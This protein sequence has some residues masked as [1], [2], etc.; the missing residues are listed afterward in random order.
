MSSFGRRSL[1]LQAPAKINLGLKILGRRADGYHELESIF[2][3]L[4]LVDE[5][6]LTVE[7]S[8]QSSVQLELLCAQLTHFGVEEA[9]PSDARNLAFRAAQRFLDVADLPVS[10]RLRL[11]KKIPAAAGLGGGSSDAAAVLRG[12]AQIF[13]Q[14]LSHEKLAELALELGADLPFFLDP[15]PALITGIGEKISPLDSIPELALLLANPG[16]PLATADVYRA[17]D[18][19]SLTMSEAGSTMR[20]LWGICESAWFSARNTLQ[21]QTQN[22]EAALLF[23]ALLRNDLEP[24]ATVLCPAIGDLRKKLAAAGAK[25]VGLSGSGPTV[26]GI[27]EDMRAARV[28]QQTLREAAGNAAPVSQPTVSSLWLEVATVCSSDALKGEHRG[29]AEPTRE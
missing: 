18:A 5:I 20:A 23:E 3:P 11:T 24:A 9:V 7:A 26:Y 25:A 12:L 22:S 14:T 19:N 16:L 28:A 13:P 27:F 2:V 15:R 29:R 8:T 6:E 1:R 21:A 17:Y 10:V 4:S